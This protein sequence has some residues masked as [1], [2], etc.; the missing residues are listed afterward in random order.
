MTKEKDTEYKI[1]TI[2]LPKDDWFSFKIIATKQESN[3]SEIV[4]ALIKDY[5][6]KHEKLLTR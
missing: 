5:I 6:K 4:C 3:M 1:F 2:R